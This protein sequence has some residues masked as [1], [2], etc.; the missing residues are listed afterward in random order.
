GDTLS[1]ALVIA[2]PVPADI[3]VRFRHA[4]DSDPGRMIERTIRGRANRFGY[5]RPSSV[6]P[7]G[8]PGEYRLDVVASFHD[9]DG[10]LWMGSRSWGG[11][12]A[13]PDS[14]ILAHG[15]R[16]I[17]N[18]GS[19]TPPQWFFASQVLR[20]PEDPADEV[21]FPYQ[22]GDVMWMAE[23]H[24]TAISVTFQD[25]IGETANVMQSRAPSAMEFEQAALVG[26]APLFSS[27]PDGIDPHFD[28]SKVDLWGYSYASVQRPLVRVREEISEFQRV[29]RH[30]WRFRGSYRGQ[31]GGGA[32]DLPNDVKFQYGGA[33]VRGPAVGQPQYAIYGSLFV[34]VS[35]D[36][37][38]GGSR[39]FP[40][41]QGNG[42]GPSGGPI[43][44][45]KGKAVDIFFHPTGVRPG[46]ILEVGD[47]ASFVGQIGPTLAGRVEITVTAPSGS[48][49]QITGQANKIGYFYHPAQDFAVE[50]AGLHK[51]GL[52]VWYDGLT[53]A[54]PVAEP[55]PTGDVLGSR[56]GEFY[57]YAVEPDSAELQADIPPLSF[58]HPSEGPLTVN[59]T[60]A[61]GT[62]L[63]DRQFTYTTLMPGFVLEEGMTS[64]P[65]SY[66]YDMP[67]LNRDFPNL[68]GLDA[69]T[70]SFLVSGT[71]AGGKK[72]HQARQVFFQGEERMAL[73]H[74]LP[75]EGFAQFGDGQGLSS[76]LILVNPSPLQTALGKAELFSS[77]G[78]ALQTDINGESGRSRFSFEVPPL[79]AGFFQ[80]DG[81]G[82]LV[83][84][85]ALLQSNIPLG[86]TVLFSGDLGVAGVGMVRPEKH[87][88]VPLESQASQG[89]ETGLA[90]ANP[91]D[92]QVS[93]EVV[94]RRTDGSE[95]G[96]SNL[97]LAAR[98]QLAKFPREIFP[99][100]DFSS[101]RGSL[102]VSSPQPII[103]MAIRVSPGQFA[104]L[105]VASPAGGPTTR[106]FA[107]F[108]DGDGISSTIVLVNPFEEETN[109]T[110]RLFASDGSPLLVDINGK[111]VEG[112]FSF[113]LPARGVAFFAGDGAGDLATGWVEVE[114]DLPVGGTILFAGGFGVA[115]VGSVEAWRR[116]LLPVESD[117][118][119]EVQT[120]VA[121][122][123]PQDSAVEVALTLRGEDGKPI[124]GG[125]AGLSLSARGQLAQFP[126]EIFDAQLIDLSNFRGTLEVSA[127]QPVVGMAIRVS[128]GEFA[129][130]PVTR[131]N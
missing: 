78:G 94:L 100:T 73:P 70:M 51:V 37:P 128:P 116:F 89:V 118:S 88:T 86:G 55:Y 38:G 39:V 25:P 124:T 99:G 49:R 64:D 72:I 5:F 122:A 106:R 18:Q 67:R 28:I 130:L 107:Q 126:S 76:S 40:P 9:D 16:G 46:S 63:D 68:D 53:S 87:F 95:I 47:I 69:V 27:R 43:M 12:V 24:S 6:I 112:V 65:T 85:S 121:L 2:P 84:G 125:S 57:F 91:A 61:E 7:L 117:L 74:R 21:F 82:D 113:S 77:E 13:P 66:T 60:P 33:V 75:I 41:F 35:D 81:Q 17:R 97:T 22:S 108:G 50:E 71:D 101:F 105:P 83:S 93:V 23:S 80:T 1:P 36:D 45:L 96:R 3:E 92:D 109:G 14:A 29:G 8:E 119:S 31:I 4:P 44:T 102:Q 103:G 59:L 110:V 56:E 131:M 114:S 15:Q 62:T 79:G 48:T 129:T 52:K 30:Y 120:G 11:V 90:L 32:G 104:T 58:V 115:G 54:G 10:Q 19:G 20:N 42:G 26:E 127:S 123:N 34:L 111:P 98:G